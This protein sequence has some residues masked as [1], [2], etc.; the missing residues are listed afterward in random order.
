MVS[1][2]DSNFAVDLNKCLLPCMPAFLP[3]VFFLP[4]TKN[5][6]R[7]PIPEILDIFKTFCCGCPMEEKCNFPNEIFDFTFLLVGT[8]Y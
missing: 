8:E 7:Q 3:P 1:L 2:V 5:I 6:L 4:S